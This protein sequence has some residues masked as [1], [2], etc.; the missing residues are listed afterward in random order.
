MPTPSVACP[1][2][3]NLTSKLTCARIKGDTRIRY[4]RCNACNHPFKT[5]QQITTEYV[6]AYKLPSE[7]PRYTKLKPSE[8]LEIRDLLSKGLYNSFDLALQYD[9]TPSAIRSI[10][11]RATWK[12]LSNTTLNP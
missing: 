10:K 7:C 11:R 5:E 9:V 6:V 8:V 12:N 2:C 3:G 4:R 1:N